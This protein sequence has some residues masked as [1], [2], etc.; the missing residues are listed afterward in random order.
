[1]HEAENA[2]HLSPLDPQKYYFEMMLANSFLALGRLE[3]AIELCRSS[4]QKNRFHLP[5]IRALLICQFELG[6]I[7]EARKTF[8]VMR[9]LQPDLTLAKYMSSG[10]QS[11]VRK[12]AA[13]ALAG[14]GLP[15]H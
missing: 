6:Q 15:Q 10:S 9:A 7:E 5:T 13:K 8:E 2:L 12:R 14:L 4:L 11:P 3:Q 1:M